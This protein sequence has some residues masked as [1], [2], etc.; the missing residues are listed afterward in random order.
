MLICREKPAKSVSTKPKN[1]FPTVLTHS[2]NYT[3]ALPGPNLQE[4]NNI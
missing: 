4:Q 1:P 3:L 2:N